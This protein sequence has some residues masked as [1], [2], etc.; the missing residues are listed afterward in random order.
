[1]ANPLMSTGVSPNEAEPTLV[2]ETWKP[3]SLTVNVGDLEIRREPERNGP[4]IGFGT[5]I[6]ID[7]KALCI[8]SLA[9][10]IAV[11]EAITATVEYYPGKRLTEVP[12]HAG[13]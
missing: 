4:L 12:S 10:R 7:G 8:K 13:P 5:K 2:T 3:K 1:M 9:L 6:L 11:D